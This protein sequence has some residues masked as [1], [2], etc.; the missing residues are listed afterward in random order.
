M[1]I[2]RNHGLVKRLFAAVALAGALAVVPATLA[3]QSAAADTP[4][5]S[6]RDDSHPGHG[7]YNDTHDL[8]S[9]PSNRSEP[10]HAIPAE[11]S[12]TYDG[13]QGGYLDIC[14][15]KPYYYACQ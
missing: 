6:Q 11:R 4:G 9:D 13:D 2:A 12:F 1:T 5:H 15:Y 7:T 8:P 3:T 10:V 14:A